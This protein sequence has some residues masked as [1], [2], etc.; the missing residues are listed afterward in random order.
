MRIFGK[1]ISTTM[2]ISLVLLVVA[3]IV[4]VWY[5]KNHLKK[6]DTNTADEATNK[7]ASSAVS[8]GAVQAGEKK[9]FAMSGIGL[10]FPN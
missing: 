8:K 5:W 7:A 4:G 10:V 6:D 9:G 3:A 1:E 2:L